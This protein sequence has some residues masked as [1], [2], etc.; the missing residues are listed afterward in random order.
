ME[1]GLYLTFSARSVTFGTNGDSLEVVLNF[2]LPEGSSMHDS[3]LWVGDDIIKAHIYDRWTASTI[4]EGIVNRRRDPSILFKNSATQYQLRVFPMDNAATRKVKITWLQP[5]TFLNNKTQISLPFSL[6]KTSKNPVEQFNLLVWSDDRFQS[7]LIANRPDL[8]FEAVSDSV[9]GNFSRITLTPDQYVDDVQ[10]QFSSPLRDGFYLSTFSEGGENFYQ[11][12]V[13]P[14]KFFPVEEN[15]KVA[16]LFDYEAGSNAPSTTQLLTAAKSALLS[17]LG[18]KD[19]FNLFFSA[20]AIHK[21]SDHWLPAHPDTIQQVFNALSNPLTNS[22]NLQPLLATGIDWVQEHGPGGEILLVSNSSQYA[23]LQ[24]ANALINDLLEVLDPPVVINTLDYNEKNTTYFFAN[25]VYYFANSYLLSNLATQSSGFYVKTYQTQSLNRAFETSFA[26]LGTHVEAFELYPSTD[27]G[28]CYGRF[29]VG[30][31]GSL[32][33]LHRPFLQIGKY[34]GSTPFS[35]EI[36][37]IY[38][39]QPWFSTLNVDAPDILIA[40]TLIREMWYGR[41]IQALE[42]DAQSNAAI[43][44]IIFNSLAERVLSKYTAFLCLEEQ[45]WICDDCE[46]ESQYTSTDDP[47]ARDSTLTAFPNPFVTKTTVL[48]KTAAGNTE[49]A[50]FEIYDLKGQLQRQFELGTLGSETRV[51]WDGA[52][53]SGSEVPAGI[54]MGMLKRGNQA[55]VMKLVKVKG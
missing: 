20:F 54:Y 40:D 17:N 5:A 38:Q 37:G 53:L 4:Y 46:D 1:C 27:N 19:S 8:S 7:P 49:R 30:V 44:N 48:I 3:W 55:R 26:N 12:A 39:E 24:P 21:S 32:T 10:L 34:V 45:S 23:A 52:D 31:S 11:M 51:D 29:N 25:G 47:G 16:L 33:N 50:S 28:F 13:L 35:L 43:G 14:G 2:N 42:A 15:R 18:V 9:A 6:L 36:N 41:L 22:S